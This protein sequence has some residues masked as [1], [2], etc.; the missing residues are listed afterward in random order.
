MINL[1]RRFFLK[2]SAALGGVSF[3]SMLPQMPAYAAD[4]SGY[5][6]MVCLF[7]RGG[8]D[9]HDLLL[10]YDQSSYDSYAQIRSSMIGAYPQAASRE[11]SNLT[12][13]NPQNAADFE[14]RSFALAPEMGGVRQL[15]EAGNAAIV[16]NIGPLV[17]PVTRE[18]IWT[19][20]ARLPKRLFSHNDQ[21]STW[22]STEPEGAQ[23][24]WGGLMG[25]YAAE[26]GAN[27]EQTFT[28]MSSSGHDVFLSGNLVQ[29]YQLGLNGPPQ[30]APIENPWLLGTAYESATARQ[31]MREHFL[32]GSTQFNNYFERDMATASAN[33]LRAS[34][35]FNDAFS[36]GTPL[37]TTFPDGY[38]GS[39]M[40]AIAE[41]INLRGP[42]QLGASRQVFLA[43]QGDFDTHSAQAGSLPQNLAEV[44]AAMT[45]F[46]QALTEMGV[47]NDVVLFTASEFGR[48]LSVNG[49]GTDHGWGGHQLVIGGAVN[50]QRIYGSPPPYDLEH[51][52]DAD[53][54][55]LI[56]TLAVEQYGAT[57]G[58]WF[59]LTSDEIAAV[60][61]NLATFGSEGLG[62]I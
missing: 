57:L 60:F 30:F 53:Q 61:P 12:Q 41:T 20:S 33:A 21:Q 36:A 11:R 62:F 16:A 49:D 58:R 22:S 4:T 27:R 35:I 7:L 45:A 52:L 25:D 1:N 46:Y 19:P 54:G 56:P 10:P 28:V 23:Y 44:D 2:S 18:T 5:K 24:G 51:D 13:L 37:S 26:A 50:G 47:E 39:Q 17:E 48:T 38:L 8:L 6:A 14:G 15:F 43:A 29:P 55:R 34:E 42:N 9:C 32:G 59:G 40:R 31:L 3:A